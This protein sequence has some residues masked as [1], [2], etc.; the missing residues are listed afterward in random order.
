MCGT[1][2]A[3]GGLTMS[4]DKILQ[5][6]IVLEGITPRIWRRFQVSNGLTFHQLHNVIQAMMGW[7]NSHLYSFTVDDNKYQDDTYDALEKGLFSSRKQKIDILKAK[8]KF[9]YTYDFGDNWEHLLVVEKIL[10]KDASAAY[11]CCIKGERN[12]PPEDCGSV[13]GYY[14]LMTVRKNKKHPEY[15]DLVEEWLGEDYD[16][17]HFNTEEINI[18]LRRMFPKKGEKKPD[19]RAR[20]WVMKK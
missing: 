6:K 9:K 3:S 17:E 1:H 5:I 20:Y 8:Q 13:P 4:K 16:P 2:L 14:H 15:E 10:P 7:T 12:C 19:G 11:P 18:E